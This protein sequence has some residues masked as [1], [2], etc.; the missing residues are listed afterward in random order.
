MSELLF[1]GIRAGKP[2]HGVLALFAQ[3]RPKHISSRG[4]CMHEVIHTYTTARY[5]PEG[6]RVVCNEVLLVRRFSGFL[7]ARD[8]SSLELLTQGSV[9]GDGLLPHAV[10]VVVL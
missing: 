6:N 10:Q 5:N 9:L 1:F 4:C 3:V 2:R 8:A 7:F